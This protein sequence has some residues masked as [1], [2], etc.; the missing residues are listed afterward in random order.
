MKHDESQAAN[1]SDAADAP[2]PPW[3]VAADAIFHYSGGYSETVTNIIRTACEQHAAALAQE[4]DM[5]KHVVA[6]QGLRLPSEVD[7]LVRE[8]DAFRRDMDLVVKALDNAGVAVGNEYED[9]TTWH[10]VTT[11]AEQRDYFTRQCDAAR[12][13]CKRCES[14][15]ETLLATVARLTAERDKLRELVEDAI[16]NMEQRD[17]GPFALA[18]VKDARAALAPTQ[19]EEKP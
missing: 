3:V 2:E 19:K 1:S 16:P 5:L 18:W 4:R 8:R 10:R 15:R 12:D 9:W 11:L 6:K 14:E 7:E 17:G 13:N